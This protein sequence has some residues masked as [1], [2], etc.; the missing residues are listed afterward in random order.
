M[1]TPAVMAELAAKRRGGRIDQRHPAGADDHVGT[2]SAF[3]SGARRARRR[4]EYRSFFTFQSTPDALALILEQMA[5]WL[6]DQGFAVAL[7]DSRR[8][9]ADGRT[10]AV[11][12]RRSSRCHDMRLVLSEPNTNRGRWD[13]ELTL[14][15][16]ED[17]NGWLAVHVSNDQGHTAAPPRL[18]RFLLDVVD[19]H[20]GSLHLTSRVTTVPA[21]EVDDLLEAVCDPDR[22]GLL[23]V[24][25]TAEDDDSGRTFS[26]FRARSSR[27]VRQVVGLGQIVLLDP[28]STAAFN[29]GIGP[30]HGIDPWTIRTYAPE[31]DPAWTSD[32]RRHRI[33]SAA[34][35]QSTGDG[36]IGRILGLSAR[37]HAADRRL[38][39][40]VAAAERDLRRATD[41]L[42]L[43]GI[44]GT[45]T[46]ARL[47]LPIG[48]Q[49]EPASVGSSG[50]PRMDGPGSLLDVLQ[51]TVGR[52]HASPL[53]D[54]VGPVREGAVGEG[55]VSEV[56]VSEVPVDGGLTDQLVAQV[57]D[58][59]TKLQLVA[60]VLNIDDVT[61][62][63]LNAY[64][65]RLEDL[66]ATEA[67]R[68]AHASEMA[69]LARARLE[70]Q[71]AIVE[72]LEEDLQFHREYAVA[73]DELRDDAD[74][75]ARRAADEAQYLR[76]Q[77]AA[78]NQYDIAFGAIPPEAY[79]S[80]PDSFGDLLVR[81]TEELAS[82]GVVFTGDADITR[83]LDTQ[84][85]SGRLVRSA[86]ECLITLAGYVEARRAGVGVSGVHGYLTDAP[87]GYPMVSRNKFAPRES[88]STMNRFG[89]ERRLPV[90][91]E[92]SADESVLME[93]HFKLGSLGLVSP[94]MHF[95]DDTAATGLV[96]VGYI[97]PHLRTEQT[98]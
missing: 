80:H 94:R 13:T 38:P 91:T 65:R 87:T 30:T 82:R 46:T 25:G 57:R 54:V 56:P 69:E 28:L 39:R 17:A 41:R 68:A 74:L 21:A 42:V 7:D 63:S 67:V 98:N 32:A 6:R 12:H 78:A 92:V 55:P 33:F 5:T 75:R 8:H 85:T 86:W 18:V 60:S 10:L 58:L 3:A 73:A 29:A 61:D 19:A 59:E 36:E 83:K 45:T 53:R 81:M 77:L 47:P 71:R 22:Q 37:A 51:S 66:A 96:Y 76:K 16:P 95:Y 1:A 52:D 97:G 34:R 27:W 89:D 70:E 93:A 49:D 64:R 15:L 62:E 2:S 48:T 24:V 20:D 35:L 11:V 79:S 72:E 26:S 84:D 4:G 90:P 9:T 50:G 40:A 44:F 23:F 43:D 88:T 31:P 14:H